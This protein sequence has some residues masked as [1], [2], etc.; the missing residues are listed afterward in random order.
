M[1]E[2]L[3]VAAL[4]SRM[5]GWDVGEGAG[6]L[7]TESVGGVVGEEWVGESVGGEGL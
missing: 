2:L 1:T 5:G 3:S 7:L 4:G 6:G